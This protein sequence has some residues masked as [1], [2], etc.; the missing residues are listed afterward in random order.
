MSGDD[1]SYFDGGLDSAYINAT[2]VEVTRLSGR[3]L[4]LKVFRPDGS[5]CTMTAKSKAP[6]FLDFIPEK[7]S[8]SKKEACVS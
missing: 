3:F 8:T 5:V 7:V 4:L 6:I 2:K 1:F